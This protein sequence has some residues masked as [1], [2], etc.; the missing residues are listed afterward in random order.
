ME[1]VARFASHVL[2]MNHSEV[3]MYGTTKEAFSRVDELVEMG[4]EKDCSHQGLLE[5][6]NIDEKPIESDEPDIEG[7]Y[8][9]A[10][11]W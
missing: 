3:A 9:K 7:G 10:A 11:A 8:F 5:L 4:L 1:D 6:K 2:I